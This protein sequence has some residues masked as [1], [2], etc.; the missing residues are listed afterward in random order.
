MKRLLVLLL[1]VCMLST[2]VVVG[3]SA[4]EAKKMDMRELEE[5]GQLHFY[6]G[7]PVSAE[8]TPNVTDAVVGDNEYLVSYEYKNGDKHAIWSDKSTAATFMDN[9]W[10]KFYLSYD[11]DRLYAAI[12]TKDPNYIKGKDGV[13]FCLGFRDNGRPVDAI[14]RYCFDIY[15]HAD[16]EKGDIST[17]TARCRIFNKKDNGDWDNPPNTEGM[18]YISDASINHD[19]KTD[20]TTVEVAFDFYFLAK[21]VGNNKAL[22]DI[23][24]YFFPFVYMYGESVPSKGDVTSQ[25][26]LWC[27]LKSDYIS[28][29]KSQFLKDYPESSYWPGIIPNIV[30]FRSENDTTPPAD[31]TTTLPN[32]TA[33]PQKTEAVTAENTSSQAAQSVTT[34]ANGNGCSGIVALS[35]MAIIPVALVGFM[36]IKKED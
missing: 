23:R 25:G 19:D 10:V 18:L 12:E 26:I 21:E 14:S 33:E 28:Q 15:S 27:Y 16:A 34:A 4:S 13:A 29:L 9:E 24:M 22:K 5:Y 2:S 36:N 1:F 20:I 7:D 32:N 31:V 6:L 11:E 17:I 30:H 3:T 8:A 35:A